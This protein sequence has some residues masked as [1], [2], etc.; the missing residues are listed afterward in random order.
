METVKK[1]ES[2]NVVENDVKK[3]MNESSLKRVKIENGT[4]MELPKQEE[5]LKRIKSENDTNQVGNEETNSEKQEQVIH[6]CRVVEYSE[7]SIAVFGPTFVIKDDLKEIGAKY[8]GW[9]QDKG[10]KRPGWI[11]SKKK[12]QDVI[13]LLESSGAKLKEAVAKAA[14]RKAKSESTSKS[15]K[16]ESYVQTETKIDKY[17]LVSYSERACAVLGDTRPIKDKLKDLNGRFNPRLT[18]NGKSEAGWIFGKKRIAALEELLKS[19]T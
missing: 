13:K 18:I 5:S 3:E 6:E 19:S 12:K 14:E 4:E 17:R 16:S 7:R 2:S 8:N 9:L 15:A 1:E 11:L 10:N